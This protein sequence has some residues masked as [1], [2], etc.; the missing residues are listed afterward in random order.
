MHLGNAMACAVVHS[1]AMAIRL[2]AENSSAPPPPRE[3]AHIS[4]LYENLKPCLLRDVCTLYTLA[5]DSD[6]LLPMLPYQI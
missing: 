3:F 2:M 6:C 5:L 4:Y 1:G